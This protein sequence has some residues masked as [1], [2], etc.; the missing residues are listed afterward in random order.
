MACECVNR[1]WCMDSLSSS[2]A[3]SSLVGFILAARIPTPRSVFL[4]RFLNMSRGLLR[5]AA[6]STSSPRAGKGEQR[7][8][9]HIELSP[10]AKRMPK[11]LKT[12]SAATDAMIPTFEATIK[13]TISWL[14]D[15]PEDSFVVWA[16]LSTGKLAEKGSKPRTLS[17]GA[18]ASQRFGACR[19]TPFGG[20]LVRSTDFT[21]ADLD[22]IDAHARHN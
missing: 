9:D 17:I 10:Y 8:A 15:H 1:R 11:I 4:F 3:K 19:R 22:S 14:Q 5:M 6:G 12:G 2:Y 18:T 20:V 7:N 16:Q 21:T 13:N